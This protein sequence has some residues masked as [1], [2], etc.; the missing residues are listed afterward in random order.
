MEKE[1]WF[2]KVS[3]VVSYI[4]TTAFSKT[5]DTQLPTTVGETQESDQKNVEELPQLSPNTLKVAAAQCL[6]SWI[7]YLQ[8][9]QTNCYTNVKEQLNT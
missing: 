1:R 3:S 7:N 2:S 5:G 6:N 8:V 4:H 9:H